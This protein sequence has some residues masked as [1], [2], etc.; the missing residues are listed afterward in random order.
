MSAGER[1][2]HPARGTC[3]G[4]VS[5]APRKFPRLDFFTIAMLIISL[6]IGSF[7]RFVDL[8]AREMSADEGASWAA[9]SAPTIRAV[10]DAQR[11]LNPGKAGLHDLALHLWVHAFGDQLFAMRALSATVG[12]LA[13]LLVFGAARELL[14]ASIESV[15]DES[16]GP[17]ECNGAAA[18]AALIFAVNLVAIKYSREVRM[19]PMVIAAVVAQT[20]CFFCAMRKGGTIA[21]AGVTIFTALALAAHIMAVLAFTG[22]GLWLF[23]IVARNRFDFAAVPV[24]R[25]FAMVIALAGGLAMLAPIAPTIIAGAAHAAATGAIEWIKRPPFWAPFSLFNKATGSVTYPAMM[26]LVV[27]AIAHG[28]RRWH[29]AIMFALLWMWAP[30]IVLMLVSYAV[31]PAFVERYLVSCFVPFFILIAI[32]IVELHA[33]SLRIGAIALMVGLA[34]GHVIAWNRRPHDAQ[35]QE[36]ARAAIAAITPQTSVNI[37]TPVSPNGTVAVIPGYAVSVV[38]YYLRTNPAAQSVHAFNRDVND[39]ARAI[40]VGDQGVAPVMAVAVDREYPRVLAKFRGVQ[41]RGR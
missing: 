16:P 9:A 31:R 27:W 20:G 41:V 40:I 1:L 10:L 23:Y 28:W 18:M 14:T 30:P 4:R 19:Y 22:D 15:T 29:D 24:R 35:W 12:V 8:G 5:E 7:L 36:A 17:V 21:Y 25:A 32:G 11:I 6:I 39:S 37:E 3:A 38:R 13:I 2:D 26:A 33:Y 34:L